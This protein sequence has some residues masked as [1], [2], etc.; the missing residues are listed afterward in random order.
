MIKSGDGNRF[1]IIQISKRRWIIAEHDHNQ[2]V[3]ITKS[4]PKRSTTHTV[5]NWITTGD[6][7]VPNPD[8]EDWLDD[9]WMDEKI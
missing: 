4:I 5:F 3:R 7:S 6:L 1:E 8:L 9:E 2:M